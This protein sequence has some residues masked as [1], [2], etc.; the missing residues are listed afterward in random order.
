MKNPPSF[1]SRLSRGGEILTQRLPFLPVG[2]VPA[3]AAGGIL[4]PK[5]QPRAGFLPVFRF[6]RKNLTLAQPLLK[7][8]CDEL[9]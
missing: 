8:V 6:N 5:L 7:E 1:R 4:R 9:R 2:P 3:A